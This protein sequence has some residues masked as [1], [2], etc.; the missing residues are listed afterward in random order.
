MKEN[1][2]RASQSAPKEKEPRKRRAGSATKER[3]SREAKEAQKPFAFRRSAPGPASETCSELPLV[4]VG[5]RFFWCCGGFDPRILRRSECASVRP[6]YTTMGAAVLITAGFGFC[7][8]LYFFSTVL[9]GRQALPFAGLWALFILATDRYIVSSTRKRAAVVL[10][11]VGGQERQLVHTSTPFGNALLRLSL[12]AIVSVVISAPLEVALQKDR[13]AAFRTEQRNE[14]RAALTQKSEK[15][16]QAAT[17]ALIEQRGGLQT[18]LGNLRTAW[19]NAD[20]KAKDEAAGTSGSVHYGLGPVYEIDRQDAERKLQELNSAKQTLGAQI[21]HIETQIAQV[22]TEVQGEYREQITQS[23]RDHSFSADF[24]ALQALRAKSPA[25][26]LMSWGLALVFLALELCP[27]LAKLFAPFDTY[28]A[29]LLNQE[30]S[31]TISELTDLDDQRLK[32]QL[33][34]EM[35]EI[36][37]GYLKRLLNLLCQ[38]TPRTDGW[39]VVGTRASNEFRDVASDALRSRRP[40]AYTVVSARTTPRIVVAAREGRDRIVAAL[41]RGV[42]FLKNSLSLV[43]VI[44]WI[45]RKIGP[46]H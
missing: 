30:G 25:I 42:E 45:G 33:W 22:R 1:T 6:I 46:W 7:S 26:D 13:I 19:M 37:A 5:Q 14:L 3:L 4:A 21:D 34:T 36:R 15:A 24:E 12:G 43:E 28:D 20:E 31:A 35:R 16:I 10:R 18:Q 44:R 29:F 40:P 32:W 39:R 27:V 8:S 11:K 9:T 2:Q 17:A 41:R 38:E 23:Q